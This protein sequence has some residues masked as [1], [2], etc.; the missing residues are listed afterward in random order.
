MKPSAHLD[1]SHGR[2]VQPIACNSFTFS[3][4]TLAARYCSHAKVHSSSPPSAIAWQY[5]VDLR[6]GEMLKGGKMK[7]STF[8]YERIVNRAEKR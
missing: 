2:L 6:L 5:T 8:L 4:P 7:T 3:E 1:N